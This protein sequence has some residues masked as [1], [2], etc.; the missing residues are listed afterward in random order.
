VPKAYHG[1]SVLDTLS[2]VPVRIYEEP[3]PPKEIERPDIPDVLQASD[4]VDKDVTISQTSFDPRKRILKVR[5]PT[6]DQI[7]F[8]AFETFPE[9]LKSAKPTYPEIARK[10]EVEGV[11]KVLV[12]IDE[13]G[14]VIRAWVETSDAPVLNDAALE[15]AYNFVFRP[16]LQR[17]IPVKATI[18]LIFDFKISE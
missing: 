3:P 10:A 15:A 12:T 9:L 16:A 4:D 17:G 8:K 2:I 11:V 14:R 13:A 6:D 7:I 18:A 5:P 1:V